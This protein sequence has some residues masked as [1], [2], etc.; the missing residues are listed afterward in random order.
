MS[1][2]RN[3]KGFHPAYL[4]KPDLCNGCAMCAEMC[5]EAGIKVYRRQKARAS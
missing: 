2:G 5:P 3:S 1:E 4:A